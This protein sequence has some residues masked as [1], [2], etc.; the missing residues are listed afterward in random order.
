M[1]KLNGK[2]VLEFKCKCCGTWCDINRHEPYLS[3]YTNEENA[4]HHGY[5]CNLCKESYI[6]R[7]I[8]F[9]GKPHIVLCKGILSN[10]TVDVYNSS[11]L[12]W[13]FSMSAEDRKH[14][15]EEYKRDPEA[16]LKKQ[17]QKCIE[18][19]AD[20]R[21]QELRL[22]QEFS[23]RIKVIEN[24][25]DYYIKEIA[26]SK[27]EIQYERKMNYHNSRDKIY[28]SEMA[29]GRN[30]NSLSEA[31]ERLKKCRLD[32]YWAFHQ[33]EKKRLEGEKQSLTEKIAILN[34]EISEIPKR[35]EGYT[36]MVE[37]Q[38][39]TQKLTAEK[40]ALGFFKFKDKKA[41]QAQIDFTNNE[42]SIIQARINSAIDEVQKHIISLENRINAINVELT[43]PR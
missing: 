11:D 38:K 12:N 17:K 2:E 13:E 19:D 32:E 26:K 39:K 6:D 9:I 7:Y 24:S 4:A 41:V 5:C 14:Q 29:I 1:L 34:K 27:S 36:D 23:D 35:T 31:K 30:Q 25:M 40:M 8:P 15:V 37:F 22:K 20:P 18:E 3:D 42:I 28:A 33:P 10:E 43:K 16:Y 21:L